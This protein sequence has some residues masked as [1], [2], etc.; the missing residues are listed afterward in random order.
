MRCLSVS[1]YWTVGLVTEKMSTKQYFYQAFLLILFLECLVEE[2]L[3]A[4]DF[5]KI[6]NT[7]GI[8]TTPSKHIPPKMGCYHQVYSNRTS[9]F[10]AVKCLETEDVCVKIIDSD[11][12]G[13]PVFSRGCSSVFEKSRRDYPPE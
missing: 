6:V 8:K 10:P 13:L 5:A 4:I 7:F 9:A 11:E 1:L 2:S 12:F 3:C